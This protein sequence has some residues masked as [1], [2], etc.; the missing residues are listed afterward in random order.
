MADEQTQSKAKSGEETFLS[1]EMTDKR[2]G[3]KPPP[4]EGEVVPRGKQSHYRPEFADR[5]PDLMREGQSLAEVASQFEVSV[6]TLHRWLS[7]FPEFREAYE[8]AQTHSV[9][10]W[11]KF[12][13]KAAEGA[14]ACVPAVLNFNLK[15]RIGWKDKVEH[16]VVALPP[17]A[18]D[19]DVDSLDLDSAAQM[20]ADK[21][22]TKK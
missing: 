4:L 20:Y 5:L 13:R 1:R 11:T 9:A 17:E 14:E 16:D 7:Q 15:N 12:A 8:L 6:A 22:L 19:D 2:R 3:Y 10:W 18:H 21:V